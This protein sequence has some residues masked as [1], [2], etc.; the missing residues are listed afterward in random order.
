MML[1][2]GAA[3]IKKKPKIYLNNT[4]SDIIESKLIIFSLQFVLATR[5]DEYEGNLASYSPEPIKIKR[6]I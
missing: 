4:L 2:F 6:N 3:K 5:R 1:E